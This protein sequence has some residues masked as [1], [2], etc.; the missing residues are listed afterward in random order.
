MAKSTKAKTEET[1]LLWYI[2][3]TYSS[4]EERVKKNLDLRVETM[5]V[6]DKIFQVI[7]PTQNEIEIKDG[8]RTSVPRR[9]F[10]G[11]LIVQMRMDD[12]SWYVVRNTPG[13][14][15]FVSAEDEGEGRPK[16]V[17]LEDTEVQAILTRLES[18]KPIVRP[19][20]ERGQMVRIK[21]GPFVDFMGAVD[22]VY[23]DRSKA[24]ILVSFFGRETPVELDFLQIE[25]T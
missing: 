6:K 1:E 15:G 13:V 11:Y 24:K 4:Q 14:T 20:F 5:D 8:H 16:P 10:P 9:V 17:P 25:K 2:V 3:H 23:P 21:D 12:E 18:A 19:G 7:V 22:D